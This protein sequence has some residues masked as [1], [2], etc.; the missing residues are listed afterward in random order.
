MILLNHN[1]GQETKKLKTLHTNHIIDEPSEETY[2]PPIISLSQQQDHGSLL[3]TFLPI[4]K[5]IE[6]GNLVHGLI[7]EWP[8]HMQI[9]KPSL[10][11]SPLDLEEFLEIGF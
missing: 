2:V 5:E 9:S 8:S 4:N 11:N 3:M 6:L 7:F 10:R 1:L